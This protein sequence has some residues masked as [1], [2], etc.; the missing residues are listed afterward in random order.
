[1]KRPNVHNNWDPLKEVWLGD[2]WPENFYDDLKDHAVRDIFYQITEWTKTDLNNIQNKLESFGVVVKRPDVSGP[3]ERY[4][5]NNTN[6]KSLESGLNYLRPPITP[7]DTNSVIGNSL[8]FKTDFLRSCFQDLLKEYDPSCVF[9]QSKSPIAFPGGANTV[10]IGRDIIIDEFIPD[11]N[12]LRMKNPM[13]AWHAEKAHALEC[14][15]KYFKQYNELLGNDYRLHY[16]TAGGHCDGCFM[17][18]RPGLLLSTGYFK[19]YELLFPDWRKINI[20]EP[21]YAHNYMWRHPEW[22]WTLPGVKA[23]PHFNEYIEKYCADWIGNF[24]ETYFEVNILMLDEK[25]LLCIGTN[26]KLFNELEKEGITCHVLPFRTRTFWDGGL[27]CITL[28]T[29]REGTLQDYYPERG[30][31]GMKNVYSRVFNYSTEEYLKAYEGK[32]NAQN[33]SQP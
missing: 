29:I 6:L 5:V 17:P 33:Q 7:R 9:D 1:M 16:A 3:K 20:A 19:D 15:D 21:T 31:M 23:P 4:I 8:Y 28:D 14:Y 27:H 2:V 12:Q 26:D 11:F 32:V 22:R 30:G 10:K 13:A 25:N 18:I 24:K